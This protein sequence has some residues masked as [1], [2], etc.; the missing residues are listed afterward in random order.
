MPS[1]ADVAFS[2]RVGPSENFYP[3]K[4]ALG[5]LMQFLGLHFFK[6]LVSSSRAYANSNGLIM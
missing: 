2:S 3:D 5:Y 4:S 1:S 6:H